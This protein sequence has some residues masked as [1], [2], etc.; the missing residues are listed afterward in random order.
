MHCKTRLELKD[1]LPCRQTVGVLELNRGSQAI[2]QP[3]F[4]FG[5]SKETSD[6]I[7]DGLEL[8][9]TERSAF[10]LGV[11]RLHIE[12]DNGPEIACSRSEFMKRP[13]EFV[14]FWEKGLMWRSRPHWIYELRR[15]IIG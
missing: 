13:V 1:S 4:V 9:W 3:M 14:R 11:Q 12:L 2:H 8:W 7:A 10:H 5:H 15:R 6:F